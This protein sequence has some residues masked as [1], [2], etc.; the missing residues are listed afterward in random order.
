MLNNAINQRVEAMKF[1]FGDRLKRI[2]GATVNGPH[3]KV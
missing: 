3:G 2:E 1:K